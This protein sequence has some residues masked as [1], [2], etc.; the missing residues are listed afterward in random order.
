VDGAGLVADVRR[1][2]RELD[3]SVVVQDV[4]S[5]D[6]LVDDSLRAERFS[7]WL[8][9]LCGLSAP[10]IFGG[11]LLLLGVAALAAALGPARRA[12]RIDPLQALRLE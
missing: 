7:T 11:A 4:R 6:G 9:S 5:M 12:A 3:A 2:V 1:R 8:V 10:G